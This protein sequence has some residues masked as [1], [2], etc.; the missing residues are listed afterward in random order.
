MRIDHF[1]L[2]VTDIEKMLQFYKHVLGADIV[3][4]EA[5]RAG[6]AKYPALLFAMQKIHLHSL[7]TREEIKA[8]SPISGSADFCFHWEGN[9]SSA[10]EHLTQHGI[11]VELG[12]IER[13]GTHGKGKS[14]YFRDPENNLLEFI[15]Y[16][17]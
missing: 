14:V 1:V 9:I 16:L 13:N 8:A 17:P 6:H 5:W 15:S 2:N 3:D 12:P 11:S 4:Y 7:Q 10:I